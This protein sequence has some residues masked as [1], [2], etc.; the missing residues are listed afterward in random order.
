M[1]IAPNLEVSARDYL[2]TFPAKTVKKGEAIFA[3]GAVREVEAGDGEI[4]FAS[5]QGS[6]LYEVT[7]AL[8]HDSWFGDCTCPLE[9][10]CE[11][12][13]AAMRWLL[14]GIEPTSPATPPAAKLDRSASPKKSF[15][16]FIEQKLGRKLQPGE[17]R[18]VTTIDDLFKNHADSAHIA[19][20]L[21][22]PILGGASAWQY[23]MHQVWPAPP[24]D[25]WEAWLYLAHFLRG[26]KKNA[27]PFL[28]QITPEAEVEAFV[29]E[30]QRREAIEHW[31]RQFGKFAARA[32]ASSA[33]VTDLRAVFAE[34]GVRLEA[35]DDGGETFELVKKT[36]Y[37][38]M[39]RE[40]GN[41]RLQ[42]TA[43]AA[44]L[45]S[46]FR[47]GQA[48]DGVLRYETPDSATALNELLR[49]PLLAERLL[50][51]RRDPLRRA[52]ERLQWKIEPASAETEDYRFTL[53]LPDGTPPPPALVAVDGQPALYV[54]SDSI[55]EASPLGGLNVT[56]TNRVPAPALETNHGLTLLDAIG[57]APPPR[58][59]ERTRTVRARVVFRCTVEQLEF[60]D[61]EVLKVAISADLGDAAASQS[62]GKDGW[63]DL[64]STKPMAA[65]LARIDRTACRATPRAVEALRVNWNPYR[66]IWDRSLG[67]KFPA[68]LTEWLAALPP[69]IEVELDPLLATLRDAPI[70]ASVRLDV[71]EAGVDW[72]DL[73]VALDVA[74]TTLTQE[75]L[76]LLLDAGGGYVRLGAKGWRRL[77][78]NLSEE[79]E[80]NLAELGLSA[81]E[82]SSEPQRLHALQLAGKKGARLMPERHFAAIERKVEEIQTR[83]APP[84]PEAIHADLRP[85]QVEGFHF[86]AYLTTNRFGGILA[87][88]MGLGKTLQALAWLAWLPAEENAQ[89]SLVVCPK[90][91]MG[92]WFAEAAHFCPTL[93][94]RLLH[95]GACDAAA[96]AAARAEADIVVANYTQLRLLE[97]ELTAAPWRA[98]ILD[99]AQYIK[100]PESQTARIAL[101]LKAAHRLA[102]SGTPIENRLLDL[103]SIMSFAMPGVLGNRAQ[104][105]KRFDQKNDPLARLRLSARVR[106]FLL[107]RTKNEVA[108]DLP[109][110]IEEDLVC[111]MDGVQATLYR[112]EL[113]RARQ[114][115]LKLKTSREL[116]KARF[117]ILTSLLRLRQICCHPA[118][119]SEKAADA[120]SAKLG[121][122]MDLLE[123]LIEEGHKVLVF[124]QFVEM[125]ALI[126]A[127][128]EKRGWR[129]FLLTGATEDRGPLVADFQKSEGAG[130]FLIS[131]RAGGFGLN[132]TAASY[133]V[134]FD[135]WWNPAVENQ[136][137][138]R[139]HRIGQTSKVIAYRL[140]VKESIEE[141]IRHLQKQ[142]KALAAD[143]LGEESFAR[144]LT[145]DDFQFLLAE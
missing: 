131:L 47:T 69:G 40:Y 83:V 56:E 112:A 123:P 12:C 65:V 68:E 38:Q 24:R 126:R 81:R 104:F 74:D 34:I 48:K 3:E 55:Y 127:E 93:R 89:P 8:Q 82:L 120:E 14:D 39:E 140:L 59:A 87:D 85:Y 26:R 75:E 44:L 144:G 62:Y 1:L 13:Y 91:V 137:I 46:A 121:A 36:H 19:E 118:L 109:D 76:K 103:W 7:L 107:R 108:K 96:L 27:P 86:L 84:V 41:G 30:W 132:L 78:F 94:V 16:A 130:V 88:D 79:D 97:S 58:I 42:L 28:A 6:L 10:D 138:D 92:N 2:H 49:N 145:L 60:G 45:W 32:E 25:A 122:L 37:A 143:I 115:L 77:E 35:S 29:H 72:F 125:L 139:T 114:Q 116:D 105:T 136:A 129:Q 50:G 5:V 99:E 52:E 102:L 142:K 128:I 73:R 110:R 66:N 22:A 141:K 9:G 106:P 67:K 64:P 33:S 111:E 98:V 54:T 133:V 43:P 70:A 95:K 63:E 124:S 61:G 134:L 101:A 11:H 31:S 23:A 18:V 119:V 53:V 80:H 135:P 20:Y 90:S 71:E 4:Y 113:K 100:N 21:L 15:P 57:V 17:K 117:N 51:V